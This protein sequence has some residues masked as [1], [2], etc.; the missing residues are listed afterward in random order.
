MV[1]S[2]IDRD[3]IIIQV[4]VI[5]EGT[6]ASSKIIDSGMR[7]VCLFTADYYSSDQTF[8]TA[9]LLGANY[10]IVPL[11][12]GRSMT[13]NGKDGKEECFQIQCI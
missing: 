12:L 2:E 9:G 8:I 13:D 1:L 7:R 3:N 10:Y 11:Y 4:P 5:F 6:Y